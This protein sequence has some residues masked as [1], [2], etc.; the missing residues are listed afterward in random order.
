MQPLEGWGEYLATHLGIELYRVPVVMLSAVIIYV[1]FL[2]LV[3]IFGARVLTVTS[4]F[5]TLVVIMLGA[6]A[7]RAVLGHPPT[8]AAG[9]IGLATLMGMEA[10]FGAVER[11]W[12]SRRLISGRPVVV[13]AHGRPVSAACR[14]THTS[15]A[16]LGSAM[17]RAGIA[18]P[19]EAQC[20]ILEPHGDYSVI[21]EGAPIS[22]ELLVNVDGADLLGPRERS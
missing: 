5:D 16:D 4:G 15:P 22:P 12:A 10:I 13:F 11:T 2:I 14:R 3:R 19:E 7:G 20:I 6:V 21:R 9:V 17:R 8:V 1:V 18:R